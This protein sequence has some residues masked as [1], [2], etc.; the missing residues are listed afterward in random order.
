[1]KNEY[2]SSS[3]K[4]ARVRKRLRQLPADR[5]CPVCHQTKVKS[6]QWVFLDK[7]QL[8]VCKSCYYRQKL[9][10]NLKISKNNLQVAVNTCLEKE[11]THLGLSKQPGDFLS[12]N[13]TD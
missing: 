5:V 12:M 11:I 2:Q 1:M 10:S 4:A 3:K 6:K 13:T 9:G 7:E 8:A